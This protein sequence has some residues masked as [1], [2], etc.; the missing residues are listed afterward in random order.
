MQ[1]TNIITTEQTP[2][3]ISASNTIF[4][5]QALT[6]LQEVAGLMSQATVT[7]PDHLRGNPA[8]CMAIIMQAMQWG[9]N[10]Y[11]V[12]QKTHL[13]NGVLGYEAQLVNAVISSSSAIVGRFHY[14]YEGDWEKCSRTRVETVK[15]TAKGGGIYEKKETIPCWTSEDEYGL[16]VRVGAVLRG[17]SEITWGE[18]VFL[19][20]VIT[21]NSPLWTS[22]PKQQLAYLA[23]KYWARLYC[24]DVILG[25]YTPDELEEP[26]EKIINPVP[27]QNYSEVS[28]QRTETIEQRIDEAWI[29]EFRQRV[30]SAAT[31]EETTALR[32]EIEDQKN[33]IGEFFAELKGKVVRR[34]HRLNAIASIE[35]MINDLPS[36]GDPEAEQK[37]TALENTL[38]AARPHL[39]ELYEAYKTTLTD[40]KPE[41]IGS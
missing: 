40:M 24:P 30:E 38:N 21:R 23:L 6:Q 16:S 33:Q 11:A 35:K 37:F 9:M 18:P 25:V 19:S 8:D 22:N 20:S 1:N 3:T 2:N 41:Y 12:A 28:E 39:G 17:E 7:V 32:Q 13:V 26:Q 27:V 10:P 29:D 15:K 34:H 5:V 4:N 36:S 14:K 31:T